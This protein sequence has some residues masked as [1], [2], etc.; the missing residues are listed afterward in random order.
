MALG[1]ILLVIA[2]AT[3]SRKRILLAV[4]ANLIPIAATL[5]LMGW[6]GIPLDV[7][8]ATIATVILGL[9]VDDTVHILRPAGQAGDDLS[10]TITASVSRSGSSL[11]MTSLI[12]CGGFMIMGLAEIRSVAWFGLLT[13]FAMATAVITDLLLLPAL[14]RISDQQSSFGQT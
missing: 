12:L 6:V 14:A 10:L 13:S 5:G 2:V 4:P 9:I 3:R 8:T 11:L 7:A 1:L